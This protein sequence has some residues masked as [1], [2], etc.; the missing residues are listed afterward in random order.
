MPKKSKKEVAAIN[1]RI[2]DKDKREYKTLLEEIAQLKRGVRVYGDTYVAINSFN[3]E[4][5]SGV[6]SKYSE[7]D[8]DGNWFDTEDFDM[9]EPS[10]VEDI[11][12]PRNLKPNLSQFFLHLDPERHVIVCEIYAASRS[13][14]ARSIQKYFSQILSSK[15]I[16]AAFGTVEA[17]FVK[18]FDVVEEIV[19]SEM[20]REIRFV[21][22]PPNPDDLSSKLAAVIEER[23][24]EQNGEQYEEKLQARKD[25]NLKLNGRSK[26]LGYIAAENGEIKG[27]KIENGVLRPIDTDDT[28]LTDIGTFEPESSDIGNFKS[29]VDRILDKIDLNRKRFGG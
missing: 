9:A 2:V 13:L 23:I 1:I 19:E 15:E 27:K 7:I 5:C 11:K 6:I 28:P 4:D 3:K 24:V 17:D 18:S 22:R 29:L 14:S 12:I 10:K 21:I 26:T 8:L 25:S 20:L 16:T